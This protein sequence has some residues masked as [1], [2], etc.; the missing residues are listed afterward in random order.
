MA[1][2]GPLAAALSFVSLVG[3][4]TAQCAPI[5][6][7]PG[8]DGFVTAS[9]MWDPDGTG[10][11]LPLAVFGGSFDCAGPTKS[12]NI[13]TWEPVTSTW[14]TLGAGVHGGDRW[15]RALTAT[16]SGD[17]VAGGNFLFAGDVVCR[18]VA[19]WDGSAWRAMGGGIDGQVD[20][21][22]ALPNGDV[23]AGGT[24]T[25]AS[26][27]V[28][29][30][31]ARW[32]GTTWL[33]LGGGVD[34][35]VTSM[36][37]LPGGVIAVFGNFQTAGTTPA[38]GAA[39]WNGASWTA[40]P[41]T[42]ISAP[43]GVTMPNGTLVATTNL[44]IAAF[45]GGAW[46]PLSPL[47]PG[48]FAGTLV[49]MPNGDLVVG[50][51][52]ISGWPSHVLRWNGTSWADLQPGVL[53]GGTISTLLALPNGDVIAG[54]GL[55][56]ARTWA[57]TTFLAKGIG[58]MRFDGVAWRSLT[59]DT[60]LMFDVV[61]IVATATGSIVACGESAPIGMDEGHIAE[62]NGTSWTPLGLGLDGRAVCIAALPTGG[63]VVSGYFTQ[64][65][66]L[67]A[68]N[69][70]IWNGSTWSALG[71]GLNQPA[72]KLLVAPNGDLIAIGDF[73]LAG[74]IQTT[75]AARWNGT[76][77]SGFDVS[78]HSWADGTVLANGTIVAAQ[79]SPTSAVLAWSGTAWSPIPGAPS[80][81][82][83]VAAHPSGDLLVATTNQVWR[84]NGSTW[85]TVGS[86]I[87][88]ITGMQLTPTGEPVLNVQG[89]MVHRL[90][91]WDGTDWVDLTPP[92]DLSRPV[93][94]TIDATG[95][96]V[97]A[98]RFWLPWFL[99]RLA[100]CAGAAA[101]GTGCDG[102]SIEATSLPWSDGTLVTRCPANGWLGAL[103][104]TGFT[105][106]APGAAPLSSF[107]PSSAAGCDLLVLP[108]LVTVPTRG[109]NTNDIHAA[110]AIPSTPSIVGVSFHQQYVGVNAAGGVASTGALRLVGGAF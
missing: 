86:P 71:S 84:W 69:I 37:A 21:L 41:S 18:N 39:L 49:A 44:G 15:V 79:F 23:V 60:G 43:I 51:V 101:H 11:S 88:S 95:T 12:A 80:G 99:E 10:P 76:S 31:I 45:V 8:I 54:G 67:A 3:A 19:R 75:G 33:P 26:G 58:V 32:N 29:D 81:S 46:Q 38:P 50:E 109:T 16:A 94:F 100:T 17:L 13:A 107:F 40:L 85:A 105:E 93:P 42:G 103:A 104:V 96:I 91:R 35:K 2:S 102:N 22:I 77:W 56:G 20:E 87:A 28:V 64:A 4:L 92:R 98:R 7:C 74:G 61:Q 25:T 70:A 24:F 5:I 30:N 108:D 65:G 106:I 48:L 89:F 110:L 68:N 9:T 97:Q 66:G 14:S 63:V 90:V 72:R 57:P 62:W 1:R 83:V 78:S 73:G 36:T 47:S 53:V 34:A 27:T 59:A 82:V 55:A 52:T 6:T